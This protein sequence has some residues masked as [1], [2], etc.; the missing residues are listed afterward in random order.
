MSEHPV[1]A[2][3]KPAK[4]SL[5]KDKD[6]YFCVCGRSRQQPFCDGSHAGTVFKPMAFTAQSNESAYLC[7]CKHTKNPPFCDGTHKQFSAEMV[8]KPGPGVSQEEGELPH[9]DDL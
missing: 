9:W 1:V 4:V 2:D 5:E 7:V 6:N 3:N 8:G